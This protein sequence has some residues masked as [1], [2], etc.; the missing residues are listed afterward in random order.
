MTYDLHL[1]LT[2]AG[3]DALAFARAD[4]DPQEG[5]VVPPPGGDWR[6][7]M[8]A[9]AAAVRAADPSL[10]I[11]REGTDALDSYVELY[12]DRDESSGLQIVVLADAADFHLPYWHSGDEARP[13]WEQAWTALRVLA[14]E[15]GF[16]VYDPQL[17]RILDLDA[18]R[19]DVLA[20]YARGMAEAEAISAAPLLEAQQRPWWKFWG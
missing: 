15:C 19:D 20:A 10:T 13:A 18:D 5:R 14:R 6:A 3:A 17:D 4:F 7:R 11:D 8:E 12:D 9:V 1:V 16:A 2:P